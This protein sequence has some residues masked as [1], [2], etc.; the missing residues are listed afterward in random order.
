MMLPQSWMIVDFN[1]KNPNINGF[2]L[3]LEWDA[4]YSEID[5]NINK[6][7]SLIPAH[8]TQLPTP[9]RYN[10]KNPFAPSIFHLGKNET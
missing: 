3:F 10:T 4:D 5:I 1:T 8:V 7:K 9:I 2:I 6:W